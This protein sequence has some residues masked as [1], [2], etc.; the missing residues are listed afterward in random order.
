MGIDYWIVPHTHWDRE[1]YLPFQDLRW[2]LVSAM[3][4]IIDTLEADPRFAH[5]MLDGQTAA[6]EDYLELRPERRDALAR[7]VASGRLAVGP[8]YVQS[9]D[10]LPTG[11]ALARNL[12][13]GRALAEALGAT[14]PVGYLPD[15]FGHSGALPAILRGF[16]LDSACLMRG[17]GKE[18]G[19]CLFDWAA[20]DGSRVLV[21][22][23]IDGYSNGADIVSEGGDAASSLAELRERQAAIGAL[24]EG[25]PLLAMNG[26]DHRPIEAR[27][28]EALVSAGLGERAKI[29]SL[30]AYLELARQASRREPPPLW[31]G[32][33]RSTYRCPITAGCLSSRHSFKRIDQET[34]VLLEDR[35]EPLAAL[36]SWV[37]LAPW[38]AK[39]LEAAWGQLL[40]NHAHD[41]ICG[42]SVDQVYRDMAYRYDQ[43]RGL[44][45]NIAADAAAGLASA[46][47]TA[48]AAEGTVFVVL[49]PGP[50][51]GRALAT[52]E[53]GRVPSEGVVEGPDG[54][55][56]PI[57]ALPGEGEAGGLFF[58]ERFAPGQVRLALGMVRGGELMN[59]RI[60]G[61]SRSWETEGVLRVELELASAKK[62]SSFDWASWLEG[63]MAELAAPGLK[64]VHALGR[65]SGPVT[66]AVP[67]E[68]P[69]FGAACLVL[70][71]RR[72]DDALEAPPPLSVGRRR[73]ENEH[74]LVRVRPDGSLDILDKA[75]GAVY[76]RANVLVDGG[77][78]GDEYNYDEP[79]RDRLVYRSS[80]PH[81]TRVRVL[82]SGP[83]RAALESESVYRIPAEMG[84]S[85]A[86]R[87]RRLVAM[88]VTRRVTLEA[89]SRRIELRTGI[90]NRARDHRLRVRFGL[91]GSCEA[92]EAGGSFEIVRRPVSRPVDGA[93]R[94]DETL[95]GPA[96][97]TAREYPP[98]THPFAGFL[99]APWRGKE[100]RRG[101]LALL[102]RGIRE[103]EAHEGEIYITLM[104]SVGMLSRG[105][106][107]SRPSHAGPDLPTP[108]AQELGAWAFEYALVVRDEETSGAA[109]FR[110]W[111]DYRSPLMALAQRPHP[112]SLG[113]SVSFLELGDEGLAQSALRASPEGSLS[114]RVYDLEGRARTATLRSRFPL[115][116]AWK[117]RMDGKRLSALELSDA[118]CS[119]EFGIG[120]YEII[121]LELARRG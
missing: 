45:A 18:L 63:T 118:G 9:D 12:E 7:L 21:A 46:I 120:P 13:R 104:R 89:G 76:K 108:E 30:A 55:V 91:P 75:S 69:A 58:D 110:E 96:S 121:T 34:S 72:Q 68:A 64:S 8:W 10:I 84:P 48:S 26:Y 70:R 3:D 114:L 109:L 66:L 107:G 37:G 82:E 119:V 93:M 99:S 115:A 102:A 14:M 24:F 86:L 65:R 61:A 98:T 16:G 31:L 67:V 44:A 73:V 85:R 62:A 50:S 77:D 42:C 49:N 2:R 43:A 17:P 11:E 87:S 4:G 51:R 56:R 59:Y 81:R 53:C 54:R 23:L 39:A 97:D 40:L 103:Y 105:D 5:F 19:R 79:P 113:R 38:P 28:P 60:V 71:E 20:K 29:G 6:A 117:T 35:A 88:P 25:L 52:I 90:D 47:D 1:W 101:C 95:F 80:A 22:Y 83:L 92:V 100:G 116:S 32:E 74:Y 78:R 41:S 36:A 27:L 111:A 57:Q 94:G 112:G 33:L 15:S 106:L